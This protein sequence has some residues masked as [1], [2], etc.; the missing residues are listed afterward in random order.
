MGSVPGLGPFC[1]ELSCSP[2]ICIGS[3]LDS[4]AT[5]HCQKICMWDQLETLCCECKCEC[6]CLLFLMWPCN[7]LVTCP[8]CHPAFVL[9]WD[10]LEQ[11][12]L[13][14]SSGKVGLENGLMNVFHRNAFLAISSNGFPQMF[15]YSDP[16]MC[17]VPDALDLSE[18]FTQQTVLGSWGYALRGY[19]DSFRKMTEK[20]N[21]VDGCGIKQL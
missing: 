7:K 17:F 13:T 9:R 16:S 21:S 10:R 14:L 18:G 4:L 1:V 11:T 12:P 20:K 8:G 19:P 6:K 15:C 3:F 5:S 2:F